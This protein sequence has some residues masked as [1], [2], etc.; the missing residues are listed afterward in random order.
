[1]FLKTIMLK[2]LKCCYVDVNMKPY[3]TI[4]LLLLILLTYSCNEEKKSCKIFVEEGEN[5]MIG[6]VKLSNENKCFSPENEN[7]HFIYLPEINEPE[8]FVLTIGSRS[9][10]LYLAPGYNIFI[11][12][13]I[14]KSGNNSRFSGKGALQNNYMMD[15]TFLSEK[16]QNNTNFDSI[17]S[18]S[19]SSF[20]DSINSLYKLR[21]FNLEKFIKNNGIN[22]KV[23]ISTESKRIF[24]SSAI[25]KNQYYRDH[26]FLTGEIP[27]LDREFDRYLEKADFND[28]F[29]LHLQEYKKFLNT[30]FERVG[31]QDYDAFQNGGNGMHSTE[32]S[33]N[34]AKKTLSD[35][36]VKNYALYKI[37]ESYVND[38]PIDYSRD[39][40]FDFNKE[41]TDNNYKELIN[42]F[43]TAL[44]KLKK[45]MPAP[46]FTF[47]DT[48]GRLVSLSDFRR[49]LVFIDIWNS[50][51][52]PCFKE[53]P[54]M[55]QL[56]R[57]YRGEE[58]VFVGISYDSD[59]TLWKKTIKAKDL[60]GVQLFANGWN[61][62][63]GKDYKVWSNPRFILIDRNGN[64]ISARAP[65]PSANADMLIEQNL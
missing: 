36:K 46:E 41:C 48:A 35:E 27:L 38:T 6:E 45:G 8:Y 5:M 7:G 1:M 32:Y 4:P 12:S 53:F 3:K 13:G 56:I 52:S 65:K 22:D 31:L 24:Y 34:R 60:K 44:E 26:K 43:Y 54:V 28:S 20:I 23:F 14:G 58:I 15:D 47:P 33:Y 40:V 50:N 16:I 61:S 63:F 11:P 51:C 59:E 2:Y 18:L 17:Y 25:E 39:L 19:P 21:V 10:N 49:R 62:R 37:M 57:K 55:E 29:S 64:F 42:D 30:Y 9:F